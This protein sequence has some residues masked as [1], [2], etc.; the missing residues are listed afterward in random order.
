MVSLLNKLSL[1]DRLFALLRILTFLGGYLWVFISPLSKTEQ[2][3]L[4]YNFS[5]FFLYS[6][7]LYWFIFHKPDSVRQIYRI[8]LYLDLIFLFWLIRLTGGFNSEFYLAFLL[9]VALHSF[10]FGMETG[11]RVIILSTAIYLAA[12]NFLITS[13]NLVTLGLRVSFFFLVGLSMGLLSRKENMDK[14]RIQNLNKE[15][16]KRQIEL[17]QEKDKLAHI[18]MGIDAGLILY[19]TDKEIIWMNKVS[20][21]WFGP[22]KIHAN[23]N[24]SSLFQNKIICKNCPTT[25]TLNNGT[26]ETQEIEYIHD[27][28]G[29][30]RFYRIT[31]APLFKENKTIDQVLELIQDITE[32]KELQLHFIQ[33]SKFAAMGELASGIAHEINNPLSSI[34]VCVQELVELLLDTVQDR[35]TIS[36]IIQNLESIKNE[37]QRCKRITT[38]LL[39]MVPRTEHRKVPLDINQ[40][41]K[42]VRLLIRYKAEREKKKIIY[43]LSDNVPMI[44]GESDALSQVFL[45][46]ILNAIEFT[47]AGKKIEVKSGVENSTVVYVKIIDQGSGISSQNI[48]KIFNP[49]F[50][51]KPT[52][53]G[54]GLGLP[55]SQRIIQNLGGDITVESVP[56]KGSTFTVCMPISES[57][58]VT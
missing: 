54:T 52:G 9:L 15:L 12:G 7:I 3:Y 28:G 41:L 27:N 18:L 2:L 50:T 5:F 32:E 19:N 4:F 58:S 23:K 57:V 33:N 24:C 31:S 1:V 53:M 30:Q 16:A 6:I 42:N 11:F 37:I 14:L 35:E 46:L 21:R 20:E 49:F 34:S 26:I 39:K 43:K 56:K 10:Y 45:N 17:E 48:S 29:G 38:G 40:I 47:P 44:M 51:T 36:E 8:A 13:E 55:I 22:I 25:K